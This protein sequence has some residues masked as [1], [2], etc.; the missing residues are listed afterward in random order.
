ME[1][2]HFLEF[3]VYVSAKKHHVMSRMVW[4]A[5]Q[6][7]SDARQGPLLRLLAGECSG[8]WQALG[9]T[10]RPCTACERGQLEM[11]TPGCHGGG[12]VWMATSGGKLCAPFV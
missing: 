9:A 7:G 11:V 5:L 8:E 2:T 12:G 10:R 1:S 3:V 6:L 4:E